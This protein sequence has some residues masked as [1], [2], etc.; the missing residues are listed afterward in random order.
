MS[1]QTLIYLVHIKNEL[2]RKRK[3][4]YYYMNVTGRYMK[5]RGDLSQP[6]FNGKCKPTTCRGMHW[7]RFETDRH[8][9]RSEARKGYNK[10]AEEMQGMTA[11]IR[12]LRMDLGARLIWDKNWRV[13]AIVCGDRRIKA[14]DFLKYYEAE[15]FEMELLSN[16]S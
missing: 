4:F 2:N 3:R 16:K 1:L 12:S 14:K 7:V 13:E 10:A 11:Q 5:C 6:Q 8:I 15:V 9:S